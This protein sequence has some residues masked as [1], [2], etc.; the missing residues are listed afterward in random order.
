MTAHDVGAHDAAAQGAAALTTLRVGLIGAGER[1]ELAL[2]LPAGARVV[3]VADPSPRGRA[4]ARDL[5]GADVTVET[6]HRRLLELDLDAVMVFSPDH[7]HAGHAVDALR[8]GA[9][10]FVEKPLATTTAD[11]DRV[12]ATAR[13]TGSRLYVG[14]NLRHAPVVR[15]MRRLIADG[16]IGEVKA[17]WCRH[18]V[19]H[20][21]DYYFTDWHADRR[22]TT[23]LLLQKGA[24]DLDVIHWL[25]GG[26][27]RH[28]TALGAEMVYRHVT[29]RRERPE[30]RM[31]DWFDADTHWPPGSLTGLNPTIDVEDVS[32]LTAR[33]DN[34]V[35]AS[36]E[37]CHFTPDYWRNYTVIGDRGRLENFGDLDGAVI[38]VWNSRRSGYRE[39]AD[40]VV[41]I[42]A[43]DGTHG[44]ADPALVA[45][46]VRFARQG[47]ATETSAVAAREAV[48][49]GTAATESL[50]SDGT[51]VDVEP[52]PADL[53]AYFDRGQ[54]ELEVR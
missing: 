22:N 38:R 11:C 19:G 21:G 44:G 34:G 24:H 2:H 31:G 35:L 54:R 28:V 52:L 14:H 7:L 20:G 46:F 53:A 17:V 12:L 10:V 26:Y 1:V 23:S 30:E 25:A 39:D 18:F 41:E 9:S 29:D 6:D 16:E 32:M 51:P 36:Y 42:E 50:R 4:H 27:T 33:L 5:F 13:E 3:A 43:E 48:A 49:A 45:E 47:G 37:Q 8:A 15:T 40:R